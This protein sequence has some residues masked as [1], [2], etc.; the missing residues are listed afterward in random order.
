VTEASEIGLGDGTP[1]SVDLTVIADFTDGLTDPRDLAF[2]PL[3]PEE[4]WVVNGTDDS[5]VI[6][7]DAPRPERTSE[8]RTDGLAI[9][10]M[11]APR[12]SDFGC[13]AA[14]C[15]LPG[16]FGSCQQSRNTYSGT[17]P[18]NA[19]MGSS[20]WSSHLSVF[21]KMNPNGLGCHLFMLH[22]SPL[23]IG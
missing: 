1:G 7:F 5:V 13:Y 6:V 12:S 11:D 8:K 10:F 16:T 17:A 23:C 14:T 2:N 15:R 19:F 18:P 4:L 20:L 9:H 3:R 22:N 21:A